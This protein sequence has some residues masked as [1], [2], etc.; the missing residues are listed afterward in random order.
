MGNI[1]TQNKPEVNITK[2]NLAVL[3]SECFIDL[4]GNV[5]RTGSALVVLITPVF[6]LP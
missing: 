6:F 1:L 2:F 5:N 4:L 3:L